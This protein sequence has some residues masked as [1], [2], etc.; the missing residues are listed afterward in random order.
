[1]QSSNEKAIELLWFLLVLFAVNHVII[2]I[3]AGSNSKW[4]NSTATM[5]AQTFESTSPLPVETTFKFPSPLPVILPGPGQGG[6]RNF[7]K[8]K[9]DLGGLEVIQVSISTTTSKRVWRTFEGGPENM[10]AS[11]FEPVNLPAGF[12]KIGFYAQPNN[13]MLFGWVLVAR[14]VSG[15]SLR[16]PVDYIQVGNTNSINVKQDGPAYIWQPLCPNGYQAVGLS[17]TTSPTKPTL[18]QEESISCVRSDLTEQSEADNTW[19]WGI[20]EMTTLSGSRPAKRGTEATGVYTGTFSFQQ[21]NFPPPSLSCLRNTRLFDSLSSMPSED[22]TRDLFRAYSPWI[23]FHP[24]EEFLP[25]SVDWVFS[26]GALL[27][28]KGNESNPVPVKPNGSNLPQG[29]SDDDLY[30]LDYPADEGARE[31][32]K[33]GDLGNNKVYLHVKPMFGATFTDIVVWIFCPFNGNARLKF[34]FIKSLSLGDIGEHIGDWEHV[35]LRISNFNGELWRVYF[36]EHS[37]GTLVEACDLEFQGGNK[38]VAYSSLHGHAMFSRPGVVVQ[39]GQ[40]GN[41]GVRNDMAKSDKFFDA[42]AGY[43]VVAGPG[44]VE[45]PWLNYLRK[46]G[47]IV[48][49]DIEKTLDGI[50]KTLPGLLRKKLRNLINKIPRE[51]LQ[52]EGPTGPKVKTSWTADE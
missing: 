4:I 12:F 26:N 32:L 13:R 16:A 44:I 39:G 6:E 7:G 49:H 46:W 31:R 29:G 41:N 33:R 27:Y 51:L 38:P 17:V 45:P 43:E 22:Q 30:W 24:R 3:E 2:C 5:S 36:S 34:L 23:Y 9:I 10:G 1:M 50:A 48:R 40:D 19:V 37:G 18:R 28:Q 20:K 42:G 15:N 47:P 25:S 14:D 11:I 21:Q 52:G 8:G 35:T